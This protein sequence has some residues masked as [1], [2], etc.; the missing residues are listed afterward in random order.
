[1][2]YGRTL[3]RKLD[4]D[5]INQIE[6][7]GRVMRPVKPSLTKS[8]KGPRKAETYRG[9]RD[10]AR[11]ALRLAHLNLNRRLVAAGSQMEL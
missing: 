10:R 5:L 1:M 8:S 7:H 6:A 3:Q 2:S 11:R 4:I 9:N